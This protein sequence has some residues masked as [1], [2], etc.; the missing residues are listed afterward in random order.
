MLLIN[1]FAVVNILVLA[2][3]LFIR[4]NNP[5]P[6]KILASI[7]IVP[8]L[9]F[10]NNINLLSAEVYQFPILYFIVQGTAALFGPLVYCYIRILCNKKIN[11][12]SI[13]FVITVLIIVADIAI[14]VNFFSM[15][16]TD[17][18]NYLKSIIEGSYPEDMELYNMVLFIHQLVYL[19]ASAM[20]L[21]NLKKNALQSVSSFKGTGIRYMAR[22]IN[23]CWI[24]TLITVVL[25]LS[26]L[27]TIYVEYIFLPLVLLII[28]Y[29]ILYYGFHHNF[30]F[31]KSSYQEFVDNNLGNRRILPQENNASAEPEDD[32]ELQKTI[33][34][35][36]TY[37]KSTEAFIKP[38]L[39][40]YSLALETKIPVKKL[41]AT[42]N[43]IQG[44]NF[45]DFIND[46]RI[47]KAIAMLKTHQN[48]SVEAI[49]SEAGFNSRSAFYRAFKKNTGFTPTVYIKKTISTG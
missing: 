13:L 45:Y 46:K 10:A 14:T 4:K 25:Y 41:S 5:L 31:S 1:I 32:D 12:K 22:F 30:I 33:N 16:I 8:G 3:L 49:A 34:L 21:A 40:L 37:L 7:L 17:R 23:L 26:P 2:A 43:K 11:F 36:E 42:I 9:N 27:N 15:G 29:F 38:D 24:L 6:N 20:L 19:S 18:T 47:E 35:L 28:F 44:K 48:Y 39:T